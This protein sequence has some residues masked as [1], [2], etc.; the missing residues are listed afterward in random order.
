MSFKDTG[1]ATIYTVSAGLTTVGAVIN[2]INNAGKGLVASLDG[3]GNLVVTD[4]QNRSVS[5]T[6]ADALTATIG[7][8]AIGNGTN[9]SQ[10]FA[11]PA[12][13][14]NATPVTN[15][16]NI[17]IT[18][19]GSTIFTAGA[20]DTTVGQLIT[21]I[22]NSGTGLV[23]SLN[24]F[25]QLLVSDGQERGTSGNPLAINYGAAGAIGGGP[26]PPINPPGG[27][28]FSVN[29]TNASTLSTYLSDSTTI[30]SSSVSLTLSTLSASGLGLSGTSL[31]SQS[32][33]KTA[34]TAL[35]VAVSTIAGDRGNLG[36]AMNR[37]TAATNV[38]NNQVQNLSSAQ[39]GITA[40][41]IGKEVANMTKFNV[42][43]Q[44]GIAALQ[45]ANQA[46]QSILKL[47]Q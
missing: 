22:N 36:A 18:G 45:Q 11:G 47:L 24:G 16:T 29:T 9:Y 34:L 39:D 14:T 46:Q 40:A 5:T 37:L 1:G 33:A 4:S 3:S 31:S 44:T 32:T 30:G 13:W 23:A 12:G 17:S 26:P 6:G 19:G 7:T 41:D 42:L 27:V 10:F 15:P 8:F 35:N 25:G 21:D 2:D 43:Q 38:M 20:G 28:V